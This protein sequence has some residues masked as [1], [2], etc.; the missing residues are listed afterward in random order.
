MDE[1]NDVRDELAS[2]IRNLRQRIAEYEVQLSA[3]R[4]TTTRIEQLRSLRADLLRSETLQEKLKLITDGLVGIF[5]ADFAWIWLTKP[6]DRC[7]SGCVHA[8]VTDGPRVC[9]TRDR[10]LHLVAGSEPYAHLDAEFLR[11]VPF[12][13]YEIGRVAAG[14]EPKSITNDVAHDPRIHDQEWVR[15]LGLVSFAGFRLLSAH[16]E[17]IGVLALFSKHALSD[18]DAVLLEDVASTAAQ[19]LQTFIIE[20]AFR[21]SEEMFKGTLFASPVALVLTQ[22]RKIKW[23]NDAYLRMFG[24]EYEHECLGEDT[25]RFYAFG[26]D[27]ERVGAMVGSAHEPGVIAET[28]AKLRRKDGAVFD[29]NIRL[30]VLDPSAFVSGTVAAISDVTV[31]KRAE[32]ALRESEERYR[33]MYEYIPSM[34]F[35]L[36]ADATILSVNEFGAAQLGYSVGELVGQS[37]LMVFHKD[38]REAVQNQFAT[39]LQNPLQ[40]VHWEFTKIRKDGSPLRVKEIARAIRG[41]DGNPVVLVVCEDMTK[42]K[43]AEESL[44]AE[45]ERFRMLS[46]KVPFGLVMIAKDGTFEYVNPS[47]I[48]IFGYDLSDVPNGRAFYQRAYP[49]PTYRHWVKSLW[50]KDLEG[51]VTGELESR[52]FEVICKA[53]NTKIIH[54]RSCKLGTGAYLMTCEDISTR[55]RAEQAL[56]D[57]EEKLKAVVYG[58]PIPMLMIDRDHKVIYWNRALEELTGVRAEEMIG[59]NQHWKAFY[60]EERPCMVDLLVDGDAEQLHHWYGSKFTKSELI[61]DAYHGE[62]SF[63]LK[64]HEARWLRFTTALIRDSK[65][66]IVGALETTED[67]TVAKQAEEAL[68]EAHAQ[69][70]RR[71]AE[72]TAELESFNYSVSHD[73]RAPLRGIDGWSLALLED[74]ADQ[75][76][77]QGRKYLEFVR[78]ETQR[79]GRLIDDLLGLSRVTSAEMRRAR[80]DLSGLAHSIAVRLHDSESHRQAVFTIQPG[81]TT[82]GDARLIEVMLTN[83]MNNAWKFTGRH[84]AAKIEFG[85]TEVGGLLAYFVRDDGAGFDMNYASKLFGAFQR[86]HQ[87]SEFPGSGVGLATVRRIVHRHGGQVWAESEVEKG[88]TFY[89]TL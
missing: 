8:E 52:I 32:E 85:R 36:D 26:E 69:L 46:D 44:R 3:A 1:S 66:N 41:A 88:A 9:L 23:V 83:L 15:T 59:T 11:R 78:T 4:I 50:T 33:T 64:S 89:F 72:R 60:R 29:A 68:R 45:R 47:F 13:C 77:E 5:E 73:L 30:R 76:S 31:R 74:C 70:E 39:C 17:P 87:T 40:P 43:V 54:F 86:M 10:C 75:I 61:P 28:D 55:M 21:L 80:V 62:D 35:T 22:D 12:C 79:M 19:T 53:G 48:E 57:S 67:I 20:D 49:D 63:P 14:P 37:V 42:R 56:Q 18:D 6:G 82:Y 16:G 24:F 34:Y 7:G 2:E 25:R 81:L 65:G 84:P 38:D 27:Y 51:L 58:S 71:V